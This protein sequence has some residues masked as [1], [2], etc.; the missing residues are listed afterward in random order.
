MMWT[1][2]FMYGLPTETVEDIRSTYKFM[3]ELNPN[4]AGLGLY[5]PFPKTELFEQGVQLGLLTEDVDLEY[6][7]NTNPKDYYFKD[8]KKR[9]L[10]LKTDEFKDIEREIQTAFNKHNIKFSNLARRALG[11]KQNYFSHP[12]ILFM[13][14]IK[15]LK[16]TVKN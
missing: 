3:E 5:N 14:I 4:Y 12:K 1:G 6:F 15:G 10:H 2:Y 7:F 13:D 9:I 11:R 8:P 16:L